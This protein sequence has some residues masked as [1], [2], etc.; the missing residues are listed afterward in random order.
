M[1]NYHNQLVIFKQ[2]RIY[3]YILSKKILV[4][5]VIYNDWK[6]QP[7]LGLEGI[8]IILHTVGTIF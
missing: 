6:A 8:S 2:I 4:N 5:Y 1:K 7:A 3:N